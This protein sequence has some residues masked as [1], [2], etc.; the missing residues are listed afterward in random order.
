MKSCGIHVERYGIHVE[1]MGECMESMVECGGRVKYCRYAHYIF[2]FSSISYSFP[3]AP[4]HL[5]QL[6]HAQLPNMKNAPFAARFLI[7]AAI[8][9][10][11]WVSCPAPVAANGLTCLTCPLPPAKH[12]EHAAWGMFSMFGMHRTR[13]THCMG[14]VSCV[15]HT[16][17]MRTANL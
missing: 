3:P 13:K 10:V 16:Q 17:N 1:S 4:S 12:K 8:L 6:C 7:L 5:P 2:L 9:C 14:H 11:W 15:W